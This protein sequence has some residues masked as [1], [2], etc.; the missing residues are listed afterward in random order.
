MKLTGCTCNF[1]DNARHFL[2]DSS[3]S[4][5]STVLGR[6]LVWVLTSVRFPSFWHFQTNLKPHMYGWLQ[7]KETAVSVNSHH[8]LSS[9]SS[10]ERVTDLFHRLD[11]LTYQVSSA[12]LY[13]SGELIT[14]LWKMRTVFGDHVLARCQEKPYRALPTFFKDWQVCV[15]VTFRLSLPCNGW[16]SGETTILWRFILFFWKR[17]CWI[18]PLPHEQLEDGCKNTGTNL[19]FIHFNNI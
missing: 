14:H 3:N 11:I 6:G 1:D 17:K 8:A 19:F 5:I 4:R 12:G 13:Q 7:F 9:D 10:L 18:A 2:C 15:E 16:K